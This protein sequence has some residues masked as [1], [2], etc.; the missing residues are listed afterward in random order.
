MENIQH[1]TLVFYE[2]IFKWQLTM[3]VHLY[4]VP[5]SPPS[6]FSHIVMS[7]ALNNNSPS[8]LSHKPEKSPTRIWQIWVVSRVIEFSFYRGIPW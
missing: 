4:H 2:S 5:S 1:K 6:E 8:P 7:I 3:Q